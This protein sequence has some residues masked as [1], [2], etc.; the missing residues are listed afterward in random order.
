M[1]PWV[2]VVVIVAVVASRIA[3]LR[4]VWKNRRKGGRDA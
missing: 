2:V 4:D 1:A 3:W